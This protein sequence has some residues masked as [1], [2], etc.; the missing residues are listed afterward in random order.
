MEGVDQRHADEE[1]GPPP[2]NVSSLPST[3]LQLMRH[4]VWVQSGPLKR[5]LRG[6]VDPS[7]HPSSQSPPFFSLY[8]TPGFESPAHL[9]FFSQ[10]FLSP[11]GRQ[12][13]ID[14]WVF[15]LLCYAFSCSLVWWGFP[16][17]SILLSVWDLFLRLSLVWWFLFLCSLQ[18]LETFAL[19]VGCTSTDSTCLLEER[20]SSELKARHQGTSCA[21]WNWFQVRAGS[22]LGRLVSFVMA[23]HLTPVVGVWVVGPFSL[24]ESIGVSLLV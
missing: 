23:A 21:R 22:F 24:C 9:A 18:S 13:A 5:A 19:Q 11:V 1:D 20:C 14:L 8:D 12:G 17:C 2:A 3:T 7:R 4:T 10:V 6:K 15:K 16:V